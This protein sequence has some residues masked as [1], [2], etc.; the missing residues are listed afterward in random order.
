MKKFVV[1]PAAAKDIARAHA[2]YEGK[3]EGLGDEF[4]AEVRA[5]IDLA[6]EHP[7][8]YP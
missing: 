1:R 7:L 3:R 5:A 4:L 6:V 2:W 8:A